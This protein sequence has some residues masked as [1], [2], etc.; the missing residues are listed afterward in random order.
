MKK[1]NINLK[2]IPKKKLGIVI[3]IVIVI[4]GGLFLIS[5]SSDSGSQELGLEKKGEVEDVVYK[6]VNKETDYVRFSIGEESLIIELYED[7]APITV[8]NFKNLVSDGFY[9][10]LSI[11]KVMKDFM[12]EGGDPNN[13]GTGGSGNNIKGEFSLND[14]ENNVSHEF[15]VISMSRS[16]DYNSA[17]SI[18]FICTGDCT[19]LDGER[20][21]FGKVIA[22]LDSLSNINE[23]IVSSTEN[24]DSVPVDEIIINNIKFVEI[25]E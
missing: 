5:K 2:E 8:E 15:G 4:I 10:G 17:S 7:E 25:E 22:G 16:F 24:G 21:A 18:F 1:S 23:V 14:V 11:Y 9:D 12:I 20:A 13:D 3:A 19:F 6:I